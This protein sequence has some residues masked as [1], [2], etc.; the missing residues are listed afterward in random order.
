MEEIQQFADNIWLVDGP[1]VRDMG[2][3]FTT[4]MTI[5]RLSNGSI[6]ISSPVSVSFA[7]LKWISE[8]GEVRYLIA[9][10]PRHVWRLASWHTLFPEAELWASRPTLFTLQ[11]GHL[12]I[13]GYLGDTPVKAWST[14]FD[15]L[16]FKGNPL[17]SE[18]LFF[19][20]DAR[21]VMLDDLIQRNPP[22]QGNALTDAILKLE[23]AQDPDG[24]VGL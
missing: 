16:E 19:H 17:L 5:V 13:T 20:K 4:R 7:T 9:A 15:Q 6:W 3:L 23:G 10:T 21:T 8:L 14:D 22:A 2:V 1:L 12:P 18:V 11:K 24:V